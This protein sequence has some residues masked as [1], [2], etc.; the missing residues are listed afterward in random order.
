MEITYALMQRYEQLS[1]Q[2]KCRLLTKCRAKRLLTENGRVVGVEYEDAKGN[3]GQEMGDAVILA[4][5]GYGAGGL[6]EDS[7]LQKIRPDLCH[8]PTTNGEHCRGDGIMMAEAIGAQSVGLQHVQVH[9]TGL[10]NPDLPDNRTLFLAA[11]ALRGEGGIIL[12]KDGN[13]F[14]ND[15][16]KRDYVT[17]RMWAHN[18]GPYRLVL[19][20]KA[21]DNIA[22]HC[23]HYCGRRVMKHFDTGAELAKEMGIPTEQLQKSFLQYNEYAKAG[24]DPFGKIYFTNTPY[25]VND[26]FYVALVTP[27]VHYTMGGLAIGSGAECVNKESSRAIPGLYAAGELTGGVHG[28]N[29][30]GGSA[31]LECVVFG[32]VS[33]R[34]AIEYLKAGPPVASAGV[35][36]SVVITVP[37]P[38]GDPITITI[39]GNGVSTG[40]PVEG[41]LIEVDDWDS[42]KVTTE[43]GKLTAGADGAEGQSAKPAETAVAVDANAEYSL[44]EVAKHKG[45]KDCWVV[46]NGDVLNVTEFLPDHPGGKMAILSFAGRDA[47]EEFNMVHDEGVVQKYAPNTIIGKLK[48]TSKL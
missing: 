47:T 37:Q 27:V 26:H 32:R 7:L 17:G 5:G 44:E 9:P 46:V 28:R 8:L 22:W 31:L 25:D 3:V 15:I 24:T 21:S 12:D 1:E 40:G 19:N 39:G 11:E 34:S 14:C 4:S 6:F 45:E 29:R 2:G 20:S 33:G 18:N 41:P 10:V 38:A 16:G 23:K 13:R 42:E 48:T 36:G 30:L 43:V 35:G